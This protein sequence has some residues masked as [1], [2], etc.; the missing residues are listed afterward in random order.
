VE[1]V[2]A[3]ARE[4]L[5]EC[6]IESAPTN[7]DLVGS[8]RGVVDVVERQ[9][10]PSGRLVPRG[11][12]FEI[13]I[14]SSHPNG[15][16]RFSHAHEIGHL[17]IPSYRGSPKLR[18]DHIT[19][20]FQRDQEEEFLCDTAAA[21]LVM[22]RDLFR[23]AVG[24]DALGID[25]LL[26][27]AEEFQVSLEAAGIRLTQCDAGEC[28][29]IVWEETFKTSQVREMENQISLAGMEEFGPQPRLRIRFASTSEGMS[30]HF[31]PREKSVA[32]DCL[33]CGCLGRTGVVSGECYLP[34]GDGPVLLRTESVAVPYRC[35]GKMQTRVITLA[36]PA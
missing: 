3:A 27:V 24:E 30:H 8:F 1:A 28:A 16:R 14:N 34:T 35:D 33:V 12:E 10:V 23:A 31:F 36:M 32:E 6:E 20:E 18:E 13:E 21:E 29:V 9:M 22:P 19:G 7:L 17:L 26:R 2:R 4:L 11:T 5:S 15:R 25:C